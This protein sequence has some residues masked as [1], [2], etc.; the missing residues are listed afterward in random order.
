MTKLGRKIGEAA[1]KATDRAKQLYD[2]EIVP[3][4]EKISHKTQ[5][6]YNEDVVPFFESAGH[7]AENFVR[8]IRDGFR[9][10]KPET[11]LTPTPT[12]TP[13]ATPATIDE[14]LTAETGGKLEA[15]AGFRSQQMEEVAL[16]GNDDTNAEL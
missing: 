11:T 7:K 16:A 10:H 13:K 5:D 8:D 14:S 4:A 1:R 2:D 9:G 3:L 12:P 15:Q 6:I